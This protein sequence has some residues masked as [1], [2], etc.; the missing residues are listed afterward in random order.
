MIEYARALYQGWC[1]GQSLREIEQSHEN[2][3]LLC[4]RTFDYSEDEVRR[5]LYQESW[6]LTGRN[7]N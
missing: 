5:Q 3:I 6:F 7:R 2:F 1:Q 4:S